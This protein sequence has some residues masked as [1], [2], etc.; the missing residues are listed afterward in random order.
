MEEL[1]PAPGACSE[2]KRELG[3]WRL[4]ESSCVRMRSLME[5]LEGYT[6]P[7]TTFCGSSQKNKTKP[8]MSLGRGTSKG[9]GAKKRSSPFSLPIKECREKEAEYISNVEILPF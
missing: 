9:A 1:P 7:L 5:L 6:N 4:I 8:P 3:A 2:V